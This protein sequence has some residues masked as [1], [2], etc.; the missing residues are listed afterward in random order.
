MKYGLHLLDKFVVVRQC[1]RCGR[2]KTM[3]MASCILTVNCQLSSITRVRRRPI[4]RFKEDSQ[5]FSRSADT[6][7]QIQGIETEGLRNLPGTSLGNT[8]YY[9]TSIFYSFQFFTL[10]LF[11]IF[12]LSV[13]L[14][15]SAEYISPYLYLEFISL[16]LQTGK[17][18]LFLFLL[19]FLY[20]RRFLLFLNF[21]L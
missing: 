16:R 6:R 4:W 11:Y 1:T 14:T 18:K 17:G 9:Y 13:F 12:I 19:L 3:A 10:F 15:T 20:Q 8:R 7:E 2:I 21:V 5:Y